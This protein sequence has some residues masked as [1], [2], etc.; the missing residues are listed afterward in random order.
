[1]GT[2]NKHVPKGTRLYYSS[3]LEALRSIGSSQSGSI[4]QIDMD[5]ALRQIV[6]LLSDV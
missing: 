2:D 1:M 3:V 5:L 4:Y 6:H